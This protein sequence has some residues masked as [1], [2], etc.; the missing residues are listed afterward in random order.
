MVFSY[1]NNMKRS[2]IPKPN[3]NIQRIPSVVSRTSLFNSAHIFG[4][5]IGLFGSDSSSTE[6]HTHT[7]TQSDIV[8]YYSI[9]C[10]NRIDIDNK[11]IFK[12][13]LNAARGSS[14]NG[15]LILYMEFEVVVHVPHTAKQYPTFAAANE[16]ST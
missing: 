13:P 15:P 10:N 4:N 2:V 6:S 5:I 12:R 1:N 8:Q 11:L 3:P 9:K 7:R 16:I 14:P